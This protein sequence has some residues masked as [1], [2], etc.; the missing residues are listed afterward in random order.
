[1]RKMNN[2]RSC[3]RV[4]LR[5]SHKKKQTENLLL[6]RALKKKPM[7]RKSRVKRMSMYKNRMIKKTNNNHSN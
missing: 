5:K 2:L 6:I 4:T 7:K 1:M 3:W